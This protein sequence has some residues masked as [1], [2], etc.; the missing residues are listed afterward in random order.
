[1]HRDWGR[2]RQSRGELRK[3]AW[4]SVKNVVQNS[5]LVL[6]VSV[7]V[8]AAVFGVESGLSKAASSI[9]G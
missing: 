9:F 3:V 4:P 5:A 6:V 8:V 2:L 7:V 1:M